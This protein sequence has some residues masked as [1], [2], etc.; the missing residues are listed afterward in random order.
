MRR[1]LA[2]AYFPAICSIFCEIS[3]IA[4][5]LKTVVTRSRVRYFGAGAAPARK[6]LKWSLVRLQIVVKVRCSAAS[7]G[8]RFA[9]PDEVAH[10]LGQ[11]DRSG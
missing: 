8:Q 5:N 6:Y 1:E 11:Q 4:F 2:L 10:R 7:V 9:L 3:E